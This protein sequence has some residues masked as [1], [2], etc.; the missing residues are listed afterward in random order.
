MSANNIIL[1]VG[2]FAICYDVTDNNCFNFWKKIR[3]SGKQIFKKRTVEAPGRIN[4]CHLVD[5]FI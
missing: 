5:Y 2:V 4:H 3:R 1:P